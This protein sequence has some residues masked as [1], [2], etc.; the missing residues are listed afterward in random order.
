MNSMLNVSSGSPG[1]YFT[2]TFLLF[3]TVNGMNFITKSPFQQVLLGIV[4]FK[5]IRCILCL[6][7]VKEDA[8]LIDEII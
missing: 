4:V 7:S 5:Q 6:I 8:I 1:R 2:R 3:I